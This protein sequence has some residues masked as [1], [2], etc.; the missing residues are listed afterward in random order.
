VNA[1]EILVRGA[2]WPDNIFLRGNL[3]AEQKFVKQR[4][5][6]RGKNMRAKIQIVAGM[7]NELER[8]HW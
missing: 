5:F 3:F 1:K 7:I 4:E 6:L 8:Q 2:V